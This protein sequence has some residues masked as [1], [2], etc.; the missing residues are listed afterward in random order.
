M[1]WVHFVPIKVDYSDLYDTIA[2][3]RGLPDGTPGQEDL[4]DKIAAAGREWVDKFWRSEVRVC[5][6][7]HLMRANCFFSYTQDITAY[8]WR[9]YLEYFR[10]MADDRDAMDFIY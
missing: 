9:M 2:F 8:E 10:L 5:S 4:G 6:V 7:S 3:F 1:P